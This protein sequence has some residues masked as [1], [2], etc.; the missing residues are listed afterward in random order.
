MRLF[1]V[2]LV[3][4]VAHC[5]APGQEPSA[6]PVFEVASVKVRPG[7][8]ESGSTG[9]PPLL[10]GDPGLLNYTG[11]S[12]AGVLARAYNVKPLQISG[13]DWLRTERYDITA[14]APDHAPKGHIPEM[15]Q[16]LLAERF[17]MTVHWDTREEMGYALVAGKTGPKLK[18][19]DVADGDA[20]PKRSESMSG[21]G[22]MTWNASTLDDFA[23][24]LTVL[25]GRPVVD[26]TGVP[27]IFDIAIDA[28]PDSMPGLPSFGQADGNS[29]FPSIFNAVRILG[30]NL[31]PRRVPVKRLVVDSAQ[32]V[33][34]EN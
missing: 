26:M 29:P 19:S 24:S 17:R 9:I 6:K 11:V 14:K 27:G 8:L 3:A 10:A 28:A 21:S 5:A 7:G 18:K 23:A 1:A 15:L 34:T 4:V 33:P 2:L 31:Q 12:L 32:K 25:V 22:H 30:L 16:N 13:P 20:P